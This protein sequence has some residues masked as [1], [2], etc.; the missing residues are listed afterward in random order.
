MIVL[1][2]NI[3]ALTTPGDSAWP[4]KHQRVSMYSCQ[5]SPTFSLCHQWCKLTYYFLISHSLCRCPPVLAQSPLPSPSLPAHE[6]SSEGSP[7]WAACSLPLL[8]GGPHVSSRETLSRPCSLS[9]DMCVPFWSH[10]C[11][12]SGPGGCVSLLRG[13]TVL[14]LSSSNCAFLENPPFGAGRWG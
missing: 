1:H 6:S 10:G 9:S 14:Y 11:L 7:T 3:L 4:S 13:N 12:I 2:C 8:R 5:Q